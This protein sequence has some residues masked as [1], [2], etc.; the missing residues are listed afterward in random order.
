MD[1]N[2]EVGQEK[3]SNQ[4]KVP[5]HLHCLRTIFKQMPGG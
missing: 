3:D 1:M 2:V 5:Y 4:V